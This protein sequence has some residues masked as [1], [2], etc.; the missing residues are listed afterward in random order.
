MVDIWQD[1]GIVS[2]LLNVV[3]HV[4]DVVYGDLVN[5]VNPLLDD[6]EYVFARVSHTDVRND[7]LRIAVVNS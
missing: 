6:L 2:K 1:E 7:V 3:E 4:S 5:G